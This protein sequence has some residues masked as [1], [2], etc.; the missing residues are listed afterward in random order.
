MKSTCAGTVVC[1]CFLILLILL[2]GKSQ[3]QVKQYCHGNRIDGAVRIGRDWVIPRDSR[4]P[5]DH[6]RMGSK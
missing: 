4:F 6:R 2:H 1:L 5:E 3:E